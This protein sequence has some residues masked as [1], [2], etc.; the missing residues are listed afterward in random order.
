[1]FSP[2][3]FITGLDLAAAFASRQQEESYTVGAE[4]RSSQCYRGSGIAASLKKIEVHFNRAEFY[5]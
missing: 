1:M 2:L 3:L 5:I 4:W